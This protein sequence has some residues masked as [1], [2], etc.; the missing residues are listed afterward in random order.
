MLHAGKCEGFEEL[1]PGF[2]SSKGKSA[3]LDAIAWHSHEALIVLV[4]AASENEIN[5]SSV[6]NPLVLAV[7]LKDLQ[8]I[9]IILSHP[10]LSEEVFLNFYIKNFLNKF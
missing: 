6:Y 3:L 2:I 9:Q 7:Y 10:K 5:D 4:N 1:K 8:S